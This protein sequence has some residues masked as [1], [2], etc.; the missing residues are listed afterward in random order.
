MKEYQKSKSNAIK[1]NKN[2]N[3]LQGQVVERYKENNRQF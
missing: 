3:Q 2:E 1:Q